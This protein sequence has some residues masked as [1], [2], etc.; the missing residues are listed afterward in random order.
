[1]DNQ[2][3]SN[4]GNLDDLIKFL[5]GLNQEPNTLRLPTP[6]QHWKECE[7]CKLKSFQ[8][9]VQ[10]VMRGEVKDKDGDIYS[11]EWLDALLE[12]VVG[13]EQYEIACKVRDTKST[14][15]SLIEAGAL[16]IPREN[17]Y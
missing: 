2:E 4:R 11:P 10:N 8:R 15:E 9:E 1:M 3:N 12:D 7:S 13:M 14:V 6:P 16:V 17:Y 5:M